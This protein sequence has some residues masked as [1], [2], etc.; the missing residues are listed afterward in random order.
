MSAAG[1]QLLALD[2]R[3][4]RWLNG[5][6]RRSSLA[7]VVGGIAFWL[8]PAE[9]VLML[10]LAVRGQSRAALRMLCAVGTVYLLVEAVGVVFARQRPFAQHNQ[11]AEL[12]SHQPRRSFPSRHVASG[13]AMA[14]V[15]APAH[16][17]VARVMMCLAWLLGLSRVAAGL[18]YPSD[19]LAGAVLGDIVGRCWRTVHGP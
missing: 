13:I 17:D 12:L 19:V 18:H 3:L 10:S 5:V 9:V 1:E 15:A 8:A 2:Q 14:A 7:S 11:V 4:A 6:I 16:P